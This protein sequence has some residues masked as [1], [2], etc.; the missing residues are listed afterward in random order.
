MYHFL[1]HK[2]AIRCLYSQIFF[3]CHVHAIECN[4]YPPHGRTLHCN[5]SYSK[6]SSPLENISSVNVSAGS[7]CASP[8]LVFYISPCWKCLWAWRNVKYQQE[9]GTKC[10]SPCWYFMYIPPC[11]K[12]Q[13]MA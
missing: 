5:K 6:S 2:F 1:L 4:S 12:C 13:R 3:G 8:M 7:F 10:F 9:Q 11:R